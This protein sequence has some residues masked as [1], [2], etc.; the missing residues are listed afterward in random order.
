MTI[1]VSGDTYTTSAYSRKSTDT[2]TYY[3]WKGKTA[4]QFAKDVYN[5][6]VA[7]ANKYTTYKLEGNTLTTKINQN[8]PLDYQKS[9]TV[10]DL[11]QEY[12]YSWVQVSIKTN[13]SNTQYNAVTTQDNWA[14][15]RTTN[16]TFKKKE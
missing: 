10:T 15:K 1:T 8:E 3:A 13:A 12:K 14:G 6:K 11:L 4:E 5:D 16:S 9:G 7:N 2:T